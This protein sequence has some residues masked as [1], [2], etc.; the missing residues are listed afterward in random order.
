MAAVPSPRVRGTNGSA[1]HWAGTSGRASRKHCLFLPAG[2]E[3]ASTLLTSPPS[4]L[5]SQFAK[6]VE[7]DS[8]WGGRAAPCLSGPWSRDNKCPGIAFRLWPLSCA[9]VC[10]SRTTAQGGKET[11]QVARFLR[12]QLLHFSLF[13]VINQSYHLLQEVL[14]D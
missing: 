8:Q 3:F 6:E 1:Q 10:L 5:R 4:L 7:Q 11:P 14:L 2:W 9:S 12:P 13:Y